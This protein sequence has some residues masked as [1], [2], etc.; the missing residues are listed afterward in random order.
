MVKLSAIPILRNH[1]KIPHLDPRIEQIS[2]YVGIISDVSYMFYRIFLT[3]KIRY[4]NI[5]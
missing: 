5:K 2:I 4:I 1:G 3:L